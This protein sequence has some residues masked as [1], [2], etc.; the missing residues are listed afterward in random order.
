MSRIVSVDYGKKR[1][2]IAV[3]DPLKIIANGLVTVPTSELFEFLN[4]YVRKEE[5][6]RIVIGRPLQLNG[7]P[8][9]NFARVQQF[10]NRW[11]KAMPAI[12]IEYFDERFTSAIAHQ[13]IIAGGVKKKTRRNDKGLVD[14][15]SATIILQDYMKSKGL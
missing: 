5:V 1:T 8:S 15:V 3:T 6:E 13:A 7:T 2:G 4:N 14:E 9:E 11:K 10:V 12:P